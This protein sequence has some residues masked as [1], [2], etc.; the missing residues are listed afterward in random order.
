L[1][2]ELV[3][4]VVGVVLDGVMASAWGSD[5]VRFGAGSVVAWIAGGAAGA[6]DSLCVRFGILNDDVSAEGDLEKAST[7][8]P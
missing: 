7:R 5:L 1:E 2:A 8:R 3:V 6:A 4:V